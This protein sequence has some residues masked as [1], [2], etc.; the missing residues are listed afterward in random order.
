MGLFVK[1]GKYVAYTTKKG[2][3]LS[4]P[5]KNTKANKKK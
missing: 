3:K 5:K 4:K 2:V 1:A